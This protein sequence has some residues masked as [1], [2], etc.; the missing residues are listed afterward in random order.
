MQQRKQ[1]HLNIYFFFI[2]E[3]LTLEILDQLHEEETKFQKLQEKKADA[4]QM[5]VRS[6]T[7]C[8]LL[9]DC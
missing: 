7:W 2:G 6:C 1:K 8:T 4:E 5:H 3:E 9:E